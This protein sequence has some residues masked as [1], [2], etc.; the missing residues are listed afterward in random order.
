MKKIMF[1]VQKNIPS[2]KNDV[3]LCRKIFTVKKNDVFLCR[4]IFDK[5]NI[6]SWSRILKVSVSEGVVLVSNGQ[7]LVSVS[8]DEVSASDYEVSVS[9]FEAE[10]PSLFSVILTWICS[11]HVDLLML[12]R[13]CSPMLS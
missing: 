3:F 13:L 6:G 10:N 9:D 12:Y 11:A 8:D 5:K 2:E 1:F 7:V 4:K